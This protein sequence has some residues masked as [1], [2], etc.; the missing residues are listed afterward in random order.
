WF[1]M[2]MLTGSGVDQSYH[3]AGIRN[4]DTAYLLFAQA[5]LG[6]VLSDGFT[7]S[8]TLLIEN[9]HIQHFI[10]QLRRTGSTAAAHNYELLTQVHLFGPGVIDY[11][12][13]HG[14]NCRKI[15]DVIKLLNGVHDLF[16]L[17]PG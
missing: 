14:G 6:Y 11:R 7:H 1:P 2:D 10:N 9:V 8:T 13:K 15:T 3:G 4:A 5:G 16:D 17:K 12:I